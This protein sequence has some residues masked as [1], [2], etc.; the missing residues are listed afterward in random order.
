MM[1]GADLEMDEPNE[2]ATMRCE[3]KSEVESEVES[4]KCSQLAPNY[5]KHIIT[6]V[7]RMKLAKMRHLVVKG[8]FSHVYLQSLFPEIIR[9]FNSQHVMYNG[10][11]AKV[12]SWKISSY[13]EVMNGCVPTT[14]P[15]LSLLETCRPLLK[16][17]DDV[18][19]VWYQQQHPRSNQHEAT[20]KRIMT[21]ITRYTPLPGEDSLLKH[22]DGAGKVDGSLVLALPMDDSESWDGFGGGLR[23]WDGHP[24]RE[25]KYDTR[26]GDV[27]FIDRMV[28]HQADPITKGIR[29]A[30]VIF[31]NV[32]WSK[33]HVTQPD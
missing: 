11:V 19:A 7:I 15:N 17:C 5:R 32:A 9:N 30:L 12:S 31:Y 6:S 16:M 3:P 26:C 25:I 2:Q 24:Q 22:V 33:M 27:G 28:W 4:E 10:G 29:W 20:F 8:L 23:F 14:S 21:F 1:D 18:F 13:L